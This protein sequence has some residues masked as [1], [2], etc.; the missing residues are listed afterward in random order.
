MGTW[1]EQHVQTLT[2]VGCWTVCSVGMMLFNKMAIQAFPLECTLVAMQMAFCVLTMLVC[3]WRSIHIGSVRDVL[4]W[5]TVA[6]LFVGMLLTSIL[7]LRDAP[8]TLVVT[9]RVLSPLLSLAVERFYPNPLRISPGVVASI[10]F[11]VFGT[12]LYASKMPQGQFTSIQWV[13]LNILFGTGD[14][15]LQRLMLAK[16]QSPVDISKTGTTLLNNLLGMGPLLLA[17]WWKGEL[18]QAP[19]A[20]AHLTP[21][22]HFSLAA[23][24]VVG[25][26]ISYCG[27]WAQS[28]I[29]ATSFLVLVNANKFVIIFVEVFAM[30]TKVLHS[31]QIV[32]AVLTIVAGVAYGKARE[33]LEAEEEEKR[34]KATEACEDDD[35]VM[36]TKP[37]ISK[38]V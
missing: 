14:R 38:G 10:A 29:S 8:M 33:T 25:V 2:G 19:A 6:P 5:S 37:L 7:A 23:S 35:D 18:A 15:L 12:G 34:K 17:A 3:C 31:V 36:E 32:G 21:M 28:L 30:H 4:R 26:G 13:I 1:S 20:I 9:F 24:C 16:D 22:G 11:M 27:I